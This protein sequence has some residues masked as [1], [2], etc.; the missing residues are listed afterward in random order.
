LFTLNRP[1]PTT[2]NNLSTDAC[3]TVAIPSTTND[4]MQSLIEPLSDRVP[5]DTK[6]WP[7]ARNERVV[8]PDRPGAPCIVSVNATHFGN[9]PALLFYRHAP[10]TTHIASCRRNASSSRTAAVGARRLSARLH[11]YQSGLNSPPSSPPYSVERL[12]DRLQRRLIIDQ[13]QSTG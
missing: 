3:A 12:S 1:R 8:S 4:D 6:H 5:T 9:A 7:P 2:S 11:L 10:T 13:Q